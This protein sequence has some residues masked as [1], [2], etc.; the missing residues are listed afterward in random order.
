MYCVTVLAV[1]PCYAFQLDKSQHLLYFTCLTVTA[2]NPARKW[3]HVLSLSTVF[4]IEYSIV[5]PAK[6]VTNDYLIL[7][8]DNIITDP[9]WGRWRNIWRTV[10]VHRQIPNARAS[11]HCTRC[12]TNSIHLLHLS[13]VLLHAP[14]S[15]IPL[16]LSEPSFWARKNVCL[17]SHF[18]SFYW[19][20]S[21]ICGQS[22]FQ[23]NVGRSQKSHSRKLLGPYSKLT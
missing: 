20:W 12:S 2:Y 5:P 11:A 13:V 21:K 3:K 15:S 9:S 4:V 17:R 6:A 14:V 16:S 1:R 10:Q 18:S 8:I 19:G 23:I 22:E 7:L